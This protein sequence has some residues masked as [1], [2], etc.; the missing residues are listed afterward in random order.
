MS[1]QTI[2]NILAAKSEPVK[3]DLSLVK[4]ADA[5]YDQLVQGA[6][7]QV[8]I[9]LKVEQKLKSLEAVA[10]KLQQIDGNIQELQKELGTDIELNYA[11]D[12]W[13]NDMGMYAER[14]GNIAS[15]L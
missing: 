10:K 4:E 2:Y 1:K 7:A 3:V 5:L 11:A 6:K 13:V 9:L 12:T 15:M 8:S 14:V